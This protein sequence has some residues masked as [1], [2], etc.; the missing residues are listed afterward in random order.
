MEGKVLAALEK[1]SCKIDRDNIEDYHRLSKKSDNVII[2]LS[3]R[4][5]CQYILRVNRDLQNL[6]LKDIGFLGENKIYINRSLWQY[7]QILWSKSKK[8]D[9]LGKTQSLY[10]SGECIKIKVHESNTLSAIEHINNF[11]YH[12]RG[13]DFSQ[14]STSNSG[15][16]MLHGVVLERV[17]LI[18][19]I[20]LSLFTFFMFLS[21]VG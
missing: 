3:R 11:E 19:C 16:W 10:I 13:V 20:D 2:K 8:L 7:C 14:T 6:N 17:L 12:L 15:S 4:K 5:D 1:V 9:S 21:F 18:S